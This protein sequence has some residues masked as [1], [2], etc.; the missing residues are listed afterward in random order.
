MHQQFDF[1]FRHSKGQYDDIIL[2]KIFVKNLYF[3]WCINNVTMHCFFFILFF[4]W[5]SLHARLNS[6]YKAWSYKKKKHKKIKAFR[7]FLQKEP[8]IC[9][10]LIILDL[11]PFRLQVKGKHYIGRE[12]QILATQGKKLL[13]DILVTSRNGDRKIML[14]IK[15]TSTPPLGKGKW[16]QLSWF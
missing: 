8:T 16:N 11:K 14:S 12:F 1:D 2:A 3:W 5:D 10:C 7:K 9:R 15:I 13:T 6:H 4:N